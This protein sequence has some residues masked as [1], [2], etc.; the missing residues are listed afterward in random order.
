MAATFGG[1][2]KESVTTVASIVAADD[3]FVAIGHHWPRVWDDLEREV[4]AWTSDDAGRSWEEHTVD[5]GTDDVEVGG[6]AVLPDGRFLAVG[7]VGLTLYRSNNEPPTT[8]A[9]ISDDGVTWSATSAPFVGVALPELVISGADVAAGAAG[10]VVSTGGTLWHSTDGRGWDLVHELPAAVATHGLDAGLEGFVAAAHETDGGAQFVLASGDG[11]EW[12]QRELVIG[13]ITGIGGDWLGTAFSLDPSTIFILASANGL[14]WAAAVDVNDLT[15]ADGPKAG[16]GM[17]SGITEVTLASDGELVVLTLGWNHC[18]V[19]R[20]AGVEVH[21]SADG[22]TWE[23]L[24][25]QPDA[26]VGAAAS[27]ERVR[28]LAGYVGRAAEAA[29][30]VSGR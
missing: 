1:S 9:W 12:H 25:L 3:R 27:T 22:R 28:V 13:D 7:V 2:G 17:E 11:R 18:C 5:L 30:W 23:K 15:A 26:F 8:A 4:R 10:I 16:Q 21:A 14:D 19:Q 24:D 6:M 29:F 20:A